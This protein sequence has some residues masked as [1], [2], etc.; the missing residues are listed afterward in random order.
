MVMPAPVQARAH[1]TIRRALEVATDLIDQRGE[2]G[3]RLHDV[4]A[5][6]GVSAGSLTHHFGS[7]EGLIAAALMERYD[8]AAQ[9]RSRSFD[10]DAS[11][12]ALFVSGLAAMI[13]SAAAGDRDEWRSA[14]IRALSYSRHRPLLRASLVASLASL[15]DQMAARFSTAPERF[16]DGG[17][18]SPAA[19]VVFSEAY[20]A[21]RIVDTVFGDA[22]PMEEWAALFT[23]LVRSLVAAPLADAAFGDR[24]APATST[25][26]ALAPDARPAIPRLDLSPDER[27]MLDLAIEVH[28]SS[29]AE[30]VK[31]RDLVLGTGLS[32]SWFARHFGEREEI[33]DHVHL[34]NLIGFSRRESELIEGAFDGASDAADLRCRLS[35]VIRHM[36]DAD[37]LGG[38]WNRMELVATAMSRPVLAAQAAPIVHVTLAR[39]A[40]AIAG[41]QERGLI[42]PDVPPRAAARFL[43]AAPLAFVLGDV[44]GVEWPDLHALAERAGG[45]LVA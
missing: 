3:V 6:S 11:D 43:W 33:V 21:G 30:A 35:D 18:V 45:T 32:R 28:R 40:A 20:S 22:L 15:Q 42:H 17:A 9:E 16:A 19:V 26:L 4:V 8:R 44:V 13:A 34:C 23:R 39:I 37:A 5:I 36:S 27:R 25:P 1:A 38:A 41:A 14:R 24:S 29:G 31:V 12:P 7:R 2:D 10:V